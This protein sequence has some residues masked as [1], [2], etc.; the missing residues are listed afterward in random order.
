MGDVHDAPRMADM[1]S[2]F[3]WSKT[4]LGPRS[5]WPASLSTAVDIMMASGH[6]MCLAWGPERTFLYNDAYI[7]ILG[8]RHP[9]ALGVTFAEAWP[10]VWDE[11][12]PLVDKTF[13][14]ETS[15]FRDMPLLMTRNGYPEDTWWSFSYSPVRG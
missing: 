14:G 7:P 8:K 4:S 9:F 11:I 5:D 12:K 2:A 13:A 10:D 1:L 15:T 6:A 3:D